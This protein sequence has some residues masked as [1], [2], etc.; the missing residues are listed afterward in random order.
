MIKMAIFVL[1]EIKPTG[2]L[3]KRESELGEF[4]SAEHS[5]LFMHITH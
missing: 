4:G 1:N 5:P 2:Q 3:Y